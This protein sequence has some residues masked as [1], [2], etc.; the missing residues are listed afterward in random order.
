MFDRQ[1]AFLGVVILLCL[2]GTLAYAVFARPYELALL[3]SVISTYELY[4]W[5]ESNERR[6]KFYYILFSTLTVYTHYIFAGILM[7]HL[8]YLCYRWKWVN[9][10]AM[11][12]IREMIW[13][14][15]GI[16]ILL[17]PAAYQVVIIHGKRYILSFAPAPTLLDLIQSWIKP[18]LV[19]FL[20]GSILATRIVSKSINIERFAIQPLSLMLLL[21]WYLL[22]SLV[23]FIYSVG[24]GASVFWPRYYI[25]SLPALSLFLG[26]VLSIIT[27]TRSKFFLVTILSGLML[28]YGGMQSPFN[29]DWS[30]AI[31]FTRKNSRGSNV[32]V[33]AYTGFVESQDTAWVIHPERRRYLLSPFAVYRLDKD[34]FLL[35]STFDQPGAAEYLEKTVFPLLKKS[36]HFYL[37]LK[38]C[39]ISINKS[40]V[41][42]DQYLSKQLE[43][44]GFHQKQVES[45][46]H[47]KVISFKKI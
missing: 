40:I 38:M 10:H 9:D 17:F 35:P 28:I 45:F 3:L 26:K 22:P 6:H 29:E 1:S 37:I 12:T 39:Y 25:W 32:P 7:V 4:L 31:A 15:L 47:V 24:S 18:Y 5:A 19:L 41:T 23:A 30:S 21:S 34:P 36:G 33:I 11:P 46:G 43:V 16:A 13:V 2:K 42:S 14:Y 20:V 8:I 44:L 27:S